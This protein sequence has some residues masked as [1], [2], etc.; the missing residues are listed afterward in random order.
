MQVRWIR[1]KLEEGSVE[2]SEQA[3]SVADRGHGRIHTQFRRC[4]RKLL[5][6]WC[7]TN[8]VFHAE[9]TLVIEVESYVGGRQMRANNSATVITG[10]Y[11]LP[12]FILEYWILE[13]TKIGSTLCCRKRIHKSGL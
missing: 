2:I 1:N 12:K 8:Q 7:S 10:K 3:G 4:G 13:Q 9:H 11:A 5:G 6:C